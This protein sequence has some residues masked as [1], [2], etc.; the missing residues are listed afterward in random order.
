MNAGNA[1]GSL[2]GVGT[3]CRIRR[4]LFQGIGKSTPKE[5]RLIDA[6]CCPLIQKRVDSVQVGDA[7]EKT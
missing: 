4:L 7:T 2:T 5:S 1:T 3:G 6:F